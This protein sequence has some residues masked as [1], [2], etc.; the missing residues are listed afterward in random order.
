MSRIEWKTRGKKIARATVAALVSIWLLYVVAINVFLS[1]SLFD[2]VVNFDK[3]MLDVHYESGWS[4]WPSTIHAKHLSI[5][6]SDSNIMWLIKL[7]EVKFEVSLLDIPRRRFTIESAHGRGL[8][9]RVQTKLMAWPDTNEEIANLPPID[10]FPAFAVRPAD[11]HHPELWD[12]EQYELINVHLDR[13]HAEDV[14]EIWID[15]YRFSG[16]ANLHGRFHLKPLREVDI[17]PVH[18]DILSG[19][20][21][22]GFGH[23]LVH[24]LGG[25]LDVYASRFDPREVHENEAARYFDIS[26]KLHARSVPLAQMP[27]ALPGNTYIDG[28]VDARD[29]TLKIER[30]KLANG[31]NVDVAVEGP[32]VARGNFIGEGELRLHA[33]VTDNRLRANTELATWRIVR[34]DAEELMRG[35]RAHLGLDSAD[36]DLSTKPFEDLH[37]VGGIDGASVPDARLTNCILPCTVHVK[38]GSATLT[39]RAE[40]WPNE[41]LVSASG[42]VRYE[43]VH[44]SVPE[45]D[46][47]GSGDVRATVAAYRWDT[48]MMEGFEIHGEIRDGSLHAEPVPLARLRAGEG[49]ID[50][51]AERLA[52]ADPLRATW[53]LELALTAL[54]AEEGLSVAHADLGLRHRHDVMDITARLDG[55]RVRNGT[56]LSFLPVRLASK[57]GRF[58]GNARLFTQNETV[59]GKVHV[60]S[61][62]VGVAS[63]KVTMIGNADVVLDIRKY[64]PK[65]LLDLGPSKIE[66]R[67]AEGTI[68]GK[69]AFTA[70]QIQVD[71]V[72]RKLDLAVPNLKAIDAHLLLAGVNAPSLDA[73]QPLLDPK[74][75][76]KLTGG[77][78]SAGAEIA[79]G[80]DDGA[81]GDLSIDAKRASFSHGESTLTA[82]ARFQA[83][84]TGISE[85]IV[86]L[87]GSR[88]ALRNVDVHGGS[89]ETSQWR[90][91]VVIDDAALDWSSGAP[92]FGADIELTADDARPVLGML[93]TPKIAG[94]F[95]TMPNV[96]LRARLDADPDGVLLRDIYARGGDV[97]IRGSYALSGDDKRGAFVV[98][99]GPLSVGLRLGNDGAHPRFFGLDGWLR[100]EEKKVKAAPQAKADAPGKP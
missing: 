45:L 15:D 5:R 1:T 9:M 81:S 50:F 10:G 18:A 59:K 89:F 38:S 83:K 55:G 78:V 95:V 100:E 87:S 43:D 37:V 99:K 70:A 60:R 86:N 47:R 48:G 67:D 32:H 31:T 4:V 90:G 3:M 66:I 28:I 80:G 76:L 61:Q 26:T 56:A 62:R 96:A 65:K 85:A 88:L 13:I 20:L 29:L 11:P 21:Q 69:P 6:S 64:V 57:D 36:L 23:T 94:A 93:E 71:G 42:R 51:R 14:R 24:D 74:G 2:R 75:R 73:L 68:A 39:A 25:T 17:G 33:D 27:F 98:S 84:V 82:D 40:A 91:D 44:A 92:A 77:A 7:D 35:P 53:D 79:F 16:H 72:A 97:A 58:D 30:G 46:G 8:S 22:R 49:T 19:E 41:H 54:A 34:A 12:D 63:S 52:L